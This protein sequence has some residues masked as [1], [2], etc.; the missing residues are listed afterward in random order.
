MS[1]DAHPSRRHYPR[2]SST[3]R[4]PASILRARLVALDSERAVIHN[5]IVQL[6]VHLA[7][8]AQT[9]AAVA[10]QLQRITYP[11]LTLPPELTTQIFAYYAELM[12]QAYSSFVGGPFVLTQVCRVWRHIALAMPRMWG[13]VQVEPG[14][15]DSS[16]SREELLQLWFDRAGKAPLRVQLATEEPRL[17]SLVTDYSD[18]F[19][20]LTCDLPP[21]PGCQ[22]EA[23]AGQLPNL[24]KLELYVAEV[25]A[26]LTLFSDAP[27]L[28]ELSVNCAR[29]GLMEKITLPWAQLT[30]ATFDKEFPTLLQIVSRMPQLQVLKLPGVRY[31]PPAKPIELNHL[32]TL[33]C[34][35]LNAQMLGTFS[36]KFLPHLH[37]PALQVLEVHFHSRRHIDK[38]AT[39]LDG[40]SRLRDITLSQLTGYEAIQVL[41]TAAGNDSRASIS[42]VTLHELSE[43]SALFYHIAGPRSDTSK[44]PFLPNLESLTVTSP[45]LELPNRAILAMLEARSSI[46]DHEDVDGPRSALQNFKLKPMRIL[47][48]REEPLSDE[49]LADRVR[50]V[51]GPLGCHV[52]VL[53]PRLT[54]VD[55]DSASTPGRSILFSLG[56]VVDED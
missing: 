7:E 50:D 1:S 41:S 35:T 49:I 22:L 51:V 32:H 39:F 43:Q 54:R 18:R 17:F 37:C 42:S 47:P 14:T 40:T 24:R 11:I 21:P 25:Q 6:R 56:E 52:H 45:P 5:E 28:R 8:L 9:R 30:E 34:S 10:S 44:A 4:L 12:A 23:I 20:T 29:S 2:N 55:S 13:H 31:T 19:E 3:E 38:L 16:E 36:L 48:Y 33:H 27:A 46:I 53:A 15:P 26:P